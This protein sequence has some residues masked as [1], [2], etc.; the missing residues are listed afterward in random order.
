LDA[1]LVIL[2][3]YNAAI[4]QDNPG[5]VDADQ[6]VSNLKALG[7][8][9]EEDLGG[10]AGSGLK[11]ESILQCLNAARIPAPV[12]PQK[13]AE[14]IAKAWRPEQPVEESTKVAVSAKKA[15]KMTLRQLVE[16]LDPEEP[17]SPVAKRL[18]GWAKGNP[19]IVYSAGRTVNVDVT[20]EQI[21]A[22]KSGH[23]PVDMTLVEGI[24]V[25]VWRLGELPEHTAKENPL[26]PDRPLRPDE[27][28]DQTLRSWT[29]VTQ[30][31]RQFLRV[32]LREGSQRGG[33]DI[34]SIKD[35]NDHIDEALSNDVNA[36]RRR[37]P[38]VSIIFDDLRKKGKLP[39][40]E[41][42]LSPNKLPMGCKEATPNHPFL[43]EGKKV[44]WMYNQGQSTYTAVDPKTVQ[45][46]AYW[47]K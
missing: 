47:R 24:P 9:S 15:E 7:A 20:F 26:Y 27:S 46:Q 1:A 45:Y 44:V 41:V 22:L 18:N 23:P 28:C 25:R 12:Q 10:S 16:T 17:E 19:F 33:F 40:L 39:Q 36:L 29:G 43:K 8:T 11:W 21:N 6:F 32:A 3:E 31:V 30:E 5:Y 42:D 37:Y 13:L 34:T 35:A 2:G 4:G 14:K 38:R